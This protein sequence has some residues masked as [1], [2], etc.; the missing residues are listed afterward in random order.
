MGSA[1]ELCS[2]NCNISR[3]EQD[4]YALQSYKRAQDSQSKGFLMKKL[5]VRQLKRT[6]EILGNIAVAWFAA[7]VISPAFTRPEDIADLLVKLI[8]SLFMTGFFSAISLSA[9]KG[10]KS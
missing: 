10:V 9:V 4:E 6:S 1:A 5:S 8:V 7:G 3:N 2:D